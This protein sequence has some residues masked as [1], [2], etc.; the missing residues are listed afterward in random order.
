MT[1]DPTPSPR[2]SDRSPD[3]RLN[4]LRPA[5]LVIEAIA[6]HLS[7]YSPCLPENATWRDFVSQARDAVR[8]A[9][10][11]G[12][13]LIPRAELEEAATWVDRCRL[14]PLIGAS[15]HQA[16][17]DLANRLRQRSRG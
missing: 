5:A 3:D 10:D 4:G 6:D 17:D 14:I 11:A 1:T 9:S 13:V 2:S 7:K 16:V 8:A 15:D 12:F